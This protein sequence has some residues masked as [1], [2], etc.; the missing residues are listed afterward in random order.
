MNVSK[1]QQENDD[2]E[3]HDFLAYMAMHAICVYASVYLLAYPC[4]H[5]KTV[6]MSFIV[7]IIYICI[8]RGAECYTYYVSEMYSKAVRKD[9]AEVLASDVVIKK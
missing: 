7:L 2:Y 3:L 9:F 5:S 4:Y 6:H 8:R 1:K